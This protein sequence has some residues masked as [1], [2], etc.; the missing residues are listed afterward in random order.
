VAAERRLGAK[1]AAVPKKA[2]TAGRELAQ[3]TYGR[4]NDP[5]RATLLQVA[6]VE[7]S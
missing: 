1:R 5:K 7:P 6:I 4:R 3:R 2:T